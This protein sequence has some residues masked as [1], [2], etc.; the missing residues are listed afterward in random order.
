M[1]CGLWG[2]YLAHFVPFLC[3]FCAFWGRA[4]VVD[5]DGP[6]MASFILRFLGVIVGNGWVGFLG[7]GWGG[8]VGGL[9]H[10][11]TAV[12]QATA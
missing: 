6:W 10:A 7:G 3:A 1:G 2:G 8:G 4:G 9:T 12:A 5:D 11:A